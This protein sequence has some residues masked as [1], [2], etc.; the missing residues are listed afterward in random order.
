MKTDIRQIYKSAE[1]ELQITESERE[2]GRKEREKIIKKIYGKKCV[3]DQGGQIQ[4]NVKESMEKI[5]GK[6]LNDEEFKKFYPLYTLGLY[7]GK[8]VV[9]AGKKTM[10]ESQIRSLKKINEEN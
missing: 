4:F 3:K 10:L 8:L 5:F 6:P 9:L 2:S 7:T 1:L